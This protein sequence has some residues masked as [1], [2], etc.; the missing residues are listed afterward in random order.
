MVVKMSEEKIVE[1]EAL[2]KRRQVHAGAVYDVRR[3]LVPNLVEEGRELLDVLRGL[4]VI[5]RGWC[6]P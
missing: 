1:E 5:R 4:C 2:R 3:D 6:M